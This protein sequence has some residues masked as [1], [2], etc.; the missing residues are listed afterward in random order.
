LLGWVILH[1]HDL[2]QKLH[3]RAG[4]TPAY[5]LRTAFGT[6]D[7]P[8]ILRRIT[9]GIMLAVALHE[10]LE[11]RAARGR[12]ITPAPVRFPSPRKP[13]TPLPRTPRAKPQAAR[14]VVALPTPQEIAAL[15]RR[16]PLGAM[17]VDICHD[18]GIMPGNVDPELWRELR[19]AIVE[20]GGSLA[21]YHA[22]TPDLCPA[23]FE[24]IEPRSGS[25]L[26]SA[27][28]GEG[29]QHRN[30]APPVLLATGPP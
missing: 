7:L 25:M 5:V 28:M 13:A 4:T 26:Q 17:I 16:K 11:R 23:P 30:P 10:R 14:D 22:G 21:K 27:S 20:Y 18:L 12:D 1:G 29:S 2:A 6:T 9:R 15:L 3:Q 24:T 19:D 8:A